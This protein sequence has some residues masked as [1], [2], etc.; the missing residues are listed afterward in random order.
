MIAS[1]KLHRGFVKLRIRIMHVVVLL[2]LAAVLPACHKDQ[3]Q[4]PQTRKVSYAVDVE[5]IL[6]M[7]CPECHNDKGIGVVESGLRMDSYESLMKGSRQGPVIKPGSA[8]TSSLY[9][10][11]SGNDKLTVNMPHGKAPLNPEEIE[12]IRIWIDNGALEN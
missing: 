4:Q 1:Q 12:T 2:L 10:L 7:H 3:A 6:K 11:V 5:P 9:L 8:L